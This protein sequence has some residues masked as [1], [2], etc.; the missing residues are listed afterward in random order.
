MG[1]WS[2]GVGCRLADVD[3][4]TREK[5]GRSV[6][7]GERTSGWGGCGNEGIGEMRMGG[8]MGLCDARNVR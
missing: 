1:V 2:E 7:S 3:G 8:G 4:W 5:V 6:E